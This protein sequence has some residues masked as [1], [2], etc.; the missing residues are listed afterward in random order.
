MGEIEEVELPE[1]QHL[2][3]GVYSAKAGL[4]RVLD[5]FQG[6]GW[7]PFPFQMEMWEAYLAARS[8][9]LHA[10][11]GMG[12]TYAAWLGPVI[13]WLDEHPDAASWPATTTEPLRV[14]WITPLRA[15]AHDTVATLRRP[16]EDM[17]LPY[18]ANPAE[19]KGRYKELVKRHH[20]DANGG[21]R[22]TED[23]L[24]R[25]IQA[26]KHLKQAGFC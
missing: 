18:S 9:L 8:G 7:K 1:V 19:I 14:L 13:A 11:T 5:W 2:P 3:E 24:R 21:D 20:P 25:I 22:S 15:L 12:K 17:G 16:L 10:P 23:R 26:Y 6:R 4:S